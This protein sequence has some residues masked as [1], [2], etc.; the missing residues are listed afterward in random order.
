MYC[1]PL[2]FIAMTINTAAQMILATIKIFLKAYLPV[3]SAYSHAI[4]IQNANRII[5][6]KT[7]PQKITI[8]G[9]INMPKINR[10]SPPALARPSIASINSQI[11]KT[12]AGIIDIV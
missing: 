3:E 8:N 9:I 11:S 2:E 10:I 1:Q 5:I 4:G 6:A 7:I 12:L